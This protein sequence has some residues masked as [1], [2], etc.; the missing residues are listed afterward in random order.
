MDEITESLTEDAAVSP[1]T[2][3]V[4]PRTRAAQLR[5]LLEGLA[6]ADGDVPAA[7]YQALTALV[8]DAKLASDEEALV[9]AQR[10]LQRLYARQL[11]IPAPA[12][13]Q[14]EQRGRVLYALDALAWVLQRLTPAAAL[15]RIEP[16]SLSHRFLEALAAHPGIYSGQV[17]DLLDNAR[18]DV[19]S[20]AGR[21]LEAAG[22]VRKQRLGRHKLWYLTPRGQ[23]VLDHPAGT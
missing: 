19:I 5:T 1:V 2:P 12:P 18:D 17:A 3:V 16:G 11:A 20:R 21:R 8:E 7:R 13:H 14:L 10:S 6:A 4:P 15:E 9:V 23:E 22:L